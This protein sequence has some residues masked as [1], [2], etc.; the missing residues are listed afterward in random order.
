MIM[1]SVLRW[2]VRLVISIIVFYVVISGGQEIGADENITLILAT[3]AAF[4]TL[5]VSVKIGR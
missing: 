3:A 5:Y 2:V 1:A 4:G